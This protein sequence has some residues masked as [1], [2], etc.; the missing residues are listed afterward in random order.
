MPIWI[1]INLIIFIYLILRPGTALSAQ[2]THS[3][4]F[5][6]PNS[7]SVP[8]PLRMASSNC[9]LLLEGSFMR[10][11]VAP[12]VT[13]CTDMY[14]HI[15]ERHI[16]AA[17]AHSPT[18]PIGLATGGGAGW[19]KHPSLSYLSP[20][21]ADAPLSNPTHLRGSLFERSFREP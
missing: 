14:T 10:V 11:V 3:R 9:P 2:A 4:V 15:K 8:P 7:R 19:G 21:P 6:T 5:P 13:A 16:H 20:F 17:A 1:W 12:G 18:R